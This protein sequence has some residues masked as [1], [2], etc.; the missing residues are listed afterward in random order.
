MRF[1]P[2]KPGGPSSPLPPF[3]PLSPLDPLLPNMG[4]TKVYPPFFYKWQSE[5]FCKKIGDTLFF[6]FF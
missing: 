6:D 3:S 5:K 2:G 1:R 4:I